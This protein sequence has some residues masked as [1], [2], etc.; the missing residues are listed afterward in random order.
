MWK[1][2]HSA[3]RMSQK[4]LP[5]VKDVGTFFESIVGSPIDC[6]GDGCP[7]YKILYGKSFRL[8]PF[9]NCAQGWILQSSI[10]I[11]SEKCY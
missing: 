3:K 9:E 6:P 5:F 7:A 10:G 1:T 4:Y 11:N 2:L 8:I